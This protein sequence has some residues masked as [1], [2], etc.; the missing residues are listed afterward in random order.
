MVVTWYR[1]GSPKAVAEDRFSIGSAGT[2][3][4]ALVAAA[5]KAGKKK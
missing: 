3:E 2:P 4:A 5:R 1:E